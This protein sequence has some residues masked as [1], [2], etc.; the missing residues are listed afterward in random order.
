MMESRG[1]TVYV[2]TS[3]AEQREGWFHGEDWSARVFNSWDPG[4]PLW[5]QHNTRCI[6]EIR[7]NVHDDHDIIGVTV[8]YS[9]QPIADAFPDHLV[10]EW[11]VGY[12]GVLSGTYKVFESNAW[13][14]Y[15]SGHLGRDDGAL[16]D[17]T[18]PN[19]FDPAELEISTVPGEYLLYLGRV[20]ELKGIQIVAEVA[21]AT[22]LPLV[23]AGQIDH[24]LSRWDWSGIEM[25]YRG[26][27]LGDDKAK[28][29]AGAR[30]LL[31]PTTYLEPFGGVAVEAMM[32]GTPAITTDFG[33]FPETVEHGVSGF[34]CSSLA[35]FVA[36][37]D[38]ASLLDRH[39]V[40]KSA[41][42]FSTE[43]VAVKYD[44][45]FYRLETVWGDGWSTL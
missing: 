29:L 19:A 17:A 11:G 30:A 34:R 38:D 12:K 26:V 7:A 14:S 15:V 22:K 1:H 37:V 41:Q 23:I 43:Q 9:Q 32:S 45:Y 25:E 42:R 6:E 24:S 21:R 40:A 28:L 16:F 33:A 10:V 35:E 36:A 20:T 3:T 44:A 39:T 5:V 2:Y 13:R 31:A 18:I 4:S 27:V 8:G